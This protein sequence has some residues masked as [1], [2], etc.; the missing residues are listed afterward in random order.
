MICSGP[1]SLATHNKFR[2]QMNSEH[3]RWR[4]MH[5]DRSFK[6]QSSLH[7]HK[8]IHK[9]LK[10]FVCKIC[11][12]AF[13]HRGS[14][15]RHY[16]LHNAERESVTCKPCGKVFIDKNSL[17]VHMRKF[18]KCQSSLGCHSAGN[19][20][21]PGGINCRTCG[22]LFRNEINSRK[23]EALHKTTTSV[24]K[25]QHCGLCFT[26]AV[27]LSNHMRM[28]QSE[29]TTNV[30]SICKLRF[31]Y[32]SNLARHMRDKHPAVKVI[33]CGICSKVCA[34]KR[35]LALHVAIRHPAK[36]GFFSKHRVLQQGKVKK[37]L[38][39]PKKA[40]SL[41][42]SVKCKKCKLTVPRKTLRDHMRIHQTMN[43][44]ANTVARQVVGIKKP[45]NSL[46]E[47][48]QISYNHSKDSFVGNQG[49]FRCELCQKVFPTLQLMNCH[50]G[51]HFRKKS[52]SPSTIST[53]STVPPRENEG[54]T[55]HNTKKLRCNFCDKEFS[56]Y[57]ML[58]GHK[59]I[60]F[61][62]RRPGSSR[63]NLITSAKALNLDK[64]QQNS[65]TTESCSP[66]WS[67]VKHA[68]RFCCQVCHKSF[69]TEG[70]L[71]SHKSHHSR[72]RLSNVSSPNPLSESPQE[73]LAESQAKSKGLKNVAF[74]RD[75]KSK[76]SSHLDK[77]SHATTVKKLLG[78]STH[79][80]FFQKGKRHSG[81]ESTKTSSDFSNQKV[82]S[83]SECK[84]YI[85]GECGR[86]F[87]SKT[88]LNSHKG[89]H[90]RANSFKRFKVSTT[91]SS[92]DFSN[93]RV[94]STNERKLYICGKCGKTFHSKMTLSRHKGHHTR[95]NSF[96]RFHNHHVA[97]AKVRSKV[98]LYGNV[99]K[100]YRCSTCLESFQS[101]SALINHK[102]RSHI[103]VNADF[104]CP[105]CDKTFS[106]KKTLS[107]HKK[108]LHSVGDPFSCLQC[109]RQFCTKYSRNNHVCRVEERNERPVESEQEL[110]SNPN[111]DESTDE[112]H[113][114]NVCLES[115]ASKRALCNHKRSHAGR[116]APFVCS[117]CQQGFSSKHS[118]LRHKKNQ[119]STTQATYLQRNGQVQSKDNQNDQTLNDSSSLRRTAH[120]ISHFPCLS[121]NKQFM[122]SSGLY[123]HE[124]K[125]HGKSKRASASSVQSIISLHDQHT[126]KLETK[127]SNSPWECQYCEKEFQAELSLTRHVEKRHDKRVW[128]AHQQS[129]AKSNSRH[130]KRVCCQ[131]EIRTIH[132]V[133][134]YGLRKHSGRRKVS[135]VQ[136][137][138]PEVKAQ[139]RTG[140]TSPVTASKHRT[141][142]A[143]RCQYCHKGFSTING[144]YK[145][146]LLSHGSELIS[147][148][149][150]P[151]ERS[152]NQ[153]AI[154]HKDI[155]ATDSLAQD[156]RQTGQ[157]GVFSD[158]NL[159]LGKAKSSTVNYFIE[160]GSHD[161]RSA[162]FMCSICQ[163]GLSS[164]RSL[165]RHKKSQ[166][167]TTQSTLLQCNGQFESKDNQCNHALNESS[168]NQSASVH[169]DL[170]DAD[171]L[172]QQ[173]SRQTGQNG[174]F[175]DDNLHLSEVKSSTVNHSIERRPHDGRSAPFM[176]SI[177]QKGLSSERSL[178]RHT[179]SQHGTSQSTLLQDY[180][181]VESKDNQ[182]NHTV[183]DSLENQSATVHE[184]VLDTDSLA[185][186]D[187][188]Q[189]GQNGV[190]SDDNPHLSETNFNT[191]K[192]SIKGKTKR[193]SLGCKF[194]CR[195]CTKRFFSKGGRRRHELKFHEK[196]PVGS[197]SALAKQ[198]GRKIERTN[199]FDKATSSCENDLSASENCE[200]KPLV[201]S[202]FY[203][204]DT[205]T[206]HGI[207]LQPTVKAFSC[208]HCPRQFFS[209]SA[210]YKH[211][212]LAHS[213]EPTVCQLDTKVGNESSA[214]KSR[215]TL[216]SYDDRS[217]ASLVPPVERKRASSS[218]CSQPLN[219]RSKPQGLAPVGGLIIENAS[220]SVHHKAVPLTSRQTSTRTKAFECKFC[221]KSF[222]MCS[223]RYKHFLL[224]HS[225]SCALAEQGF[226][227]LDNVSVN[228]PLQTLP[229]QATSKDNVSIGH[230]LNEGCVS[231]DKVV[232]ILFSVP[233]SDSKVVSIF[234]ED[235]E[236]YNCRFCSTFF[237]SRGDLVSHVNEK[238]N[239]AGKAMC[240]IC[241]PSRPALRTI[242][243]PFQSNS[244][245]SL[246]NRHTTRSKLTLGKGMSLC[247]KK[248]AQSKLSMRPTRKSNI[249][250]EK[251]FRCDIC[252]LIL[253]A[254][255]KV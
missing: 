221:S 71:R 230:D 3:D 120:G 203:R 172:V 39:P 145:H 138:K 215:E 70:S 190:S 34:D 38:Q 9:G 165:L 216:F 226:V 17:K 233:D 135:G 55:K 8:N 175:S 240:R 131:N 234:E 139:S 154:V 181:Q 151:H 115:F 243:D 128:L 202:S 176:C 207:N 88:T 91:N 51:S 206:A 246:R 2:C 201:R 208:Q 180:G 1:I 126:C 44:N 18:H 237:R 148:S 103:G 106:S 42:D 199:P 57:A 162:P 247:G 177:C 228:R 248:V 54:H 127:N 6:S 156:S 107:V 163:K 152:K 64:C 223:L 105:F 166:H 75:F 144:R 232:E 78:N 112:K 125:N 191:V 24:R 153:S 188:S 238:H 56:S 147:P 227:T 4:C 33:K 41:V 229:H 217:N 63:N 69:L 225:R 122:T 48:R 186:Q 87:H 211:I 142:R 123:K 94:S 249:R 140:L 185:Q 149:S 58:C 189:T 7:I 74:S 82:T 113:E 84:V 96:K 200:E 242:S 209:I 45:G 173:D 192:H 76:I 15:K 90:K 95:A 255:S 168:E 85:C 65:S 89:H 130:Q 98:I 193:A 164:E 79:K 68:G 159:H 204:D 28:H 23:H 250:R 22:K 184:D 133:K 111:V 37:N 210:R 62:K 132:D 72:A 118:L 93:Q 101:S 59:G 25:C 14:R 241:S 66:Y 178:L 219:K 143:F 5:C 117:I 116:R 169:E 194:S 13:S 196:R 77:N 236:P 27:S 83:T 47:R 43:A 52:A 187:S 141:V 171:S 30:C 251:G 183:N 100:P 36:R 158:D 86:K 136:G 31:T 224:V 124:R 80:N 29:T 214:T 102:R 32:S 114:C 231:Q 40:I 49:G 121:C 109:N 161:G 53:P 26:S 104:V 46:K 179:K 198:K 60:H 67:S 212:L 99:S 182:S 129:E 61:R 21:K 108:R 11:G 197:S 245:K 254:K 12:K 134:K 157:N 16:S 81:K 35:L 19:H 213:G 252:P 160:G 97:K 50:K 73:S 218:S 220:N 174:I 205:K 222:S 119:H 155:M 146:M 150:A 244:L 10:P 92:S 20:A 110:R 137:Y 167:G 195:Y 170:M 253:S 235:L 239:N